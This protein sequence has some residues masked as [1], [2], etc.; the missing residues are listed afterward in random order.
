MTTTAMNE[1]PTEVADAIIKTPPWVLKCYDP[2][3]LC[4]TY[5]ITLLPPPP[6]SLPL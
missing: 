1:Q 4:Y 6:H 2:L 3:F 5:D